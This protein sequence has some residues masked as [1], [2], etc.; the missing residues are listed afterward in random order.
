VSCAVDNTADPG[1]WDENR[2][3]G[4]YI[5]DSDQVIAYY[6]RSGTTTARCRWDPTVGEDVVFLATP[7]TW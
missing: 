1:W 5:T 7:G 4:P 3:W 6:Y 2:V